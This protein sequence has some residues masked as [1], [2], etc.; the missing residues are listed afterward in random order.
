MAIDI[1]LTLATLA[2]PLLLISATLAL[3]HIK[4]QLRT[5]DVK[6]VVMTNKIVADKFKNIFNLNILKKNSYMSS[7]LYNEY[8]T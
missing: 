3:S 1:L 2:L 7:I 4:F 8:I 6:N 5:A